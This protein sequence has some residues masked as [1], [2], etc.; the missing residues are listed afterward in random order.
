MRRTPGIHHI[1]A[2]ASE[3]QVNLDFYTNVL[4]LRLVK[5]TVNYDD[6]GTYHLYFGDRLGR[7]GTIMTFFPWP[8]ASRGRTG[9]GQA[10]A[11]A[12][13]VPGA[14][15]AFWV[16]R[17]ARLGLDFEMTAKRFDDEVLAVRDPDGMALE[18]VASPGAKTGETWQA[19]P[20]P[21]EYRI[22]GFHSVTLSVEG[23]ERTA[24][25]LADTLGFRAVKDEG[26]R[27]RYG[28]GA[29]GPG[30]MV[31]LVCL[32]AGRPGQLG[33]GTVHHVAWRA[34]HAEEQRAWREGLAGLGYNVTPIIDRTYF[35]SIYFREPG[36]VLFEIATDL[37]GFAVDEPPDRL[38]GRLILPNWLEPTR[39][40]LVK[41]LPALRGPEGQRFP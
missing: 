7:P 33:A 38:G 20:V 28:T 14:A 36:G 16:D 29:E 10:T 21:E 12:F 17:F 24:R 22:C 2:I 32:P 27:F 11:T 23:Y 13:A 18:L 3:P 1:T 41:A 19:G 37:P 34:Q 39:A 40:E 31:D 15:L 6:P 35:H 9:T 30:A 25:L 26:N 8:G 5:L 4:G